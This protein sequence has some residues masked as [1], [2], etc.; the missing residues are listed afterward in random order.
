[1][2]N[3]KNA[4]KF[5]IRVSGAFVGNLVCGKGNTVR[6]DRHNRHFN[7]KWW[8]LDITKIKQKAYSMAA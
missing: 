6:D 4:V 8:W 5:R 1:M 7:S 3:N 2:G